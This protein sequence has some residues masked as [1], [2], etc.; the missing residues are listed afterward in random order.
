MQASMD[1]EM[2]ASCVLA[3]R[4][5]DATRYAIQQ[6]ALRRPEAGTGGRR[7]PGRWALLSGLAARRRGRPALET[8]GR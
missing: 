8:A 4:E 6:R 3:Q 5:R 1:N 7:G 2:Y